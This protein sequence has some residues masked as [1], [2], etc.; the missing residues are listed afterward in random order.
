[1]S[2]NLAKPTAPLGDGAPTVLND[3]EWYIALGE[4]HTLGDAPGYL[5]VHASA[6]GGFADCVGTFE[7]ERAGSGRARIFVSFDEETNSDSQLVATGV[8]RMDAIVALWK[9]R[10]QAHCRRY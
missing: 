8:A 3:G 10:H 7:R 6:N 1:M 4:G 2:M 9:S 5:H